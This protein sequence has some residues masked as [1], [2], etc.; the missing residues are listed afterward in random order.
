MCRVLCDH[1]HEVVALSRSG[2]TIPDVEQSHAV[3]LATELPSAEVLAD[4]EVVFHLAGIAHRQAASHDYE[5]VNHQATV[6]LARSAAEAG[7][8]CFVFVS[9]V[10]AMG[11]AEG[12]LQRAEGDVQAPTD[13]Y[14]RSKFL[15]E[16]DLR[17]ACAGG[18]MSLVILRPALVYGP[19]VKGNLQRLAGAVQRGLPRPPE[20]GARS[21]IS[22]HDL[23]LLMQ[24]LGQSPP[25]GVHTWVVTDGERYSTR[26]LYDVLRLASGAGP[27]RA[28][29]P[30][31][32]WRLAAALVDLPG[33]GGSE[34]TYER[35]FGTELY[36]NAALLRDTGWRPRQQFDQDVARMILDP[37]GDG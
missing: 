30:G 12:A 37:G 2:E 4:V 27:G 36:S 35:L 3:D 16:R 20:R 19:G 14:G 23:A 28:W 17:Q 26:R 21:M 8:S 29:L 18:P 25:A 15:A 7:V 1:Q 11:T 6:S 22:V 34:G 24:F 9:S 10:R 31:W 33:R 32:F 5:Q 13:D